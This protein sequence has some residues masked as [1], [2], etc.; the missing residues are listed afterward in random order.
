MCNVYLIFISKFYAD[1]LL[2]PSALLMHVFL[3]EL[4]REIATF[5]NSFSRKTKQKKFPELRKFHE[6]KKFIK[7]Y[8][9]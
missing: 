8:T 4:F 6:K 1:R 3:H 9:S 2:T 7:N 5:C